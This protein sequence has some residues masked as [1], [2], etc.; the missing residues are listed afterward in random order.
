MALFAKES[1]LFLFFSIEN[2]ERK[3]NYRISML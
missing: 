1:D 2:N 3:R